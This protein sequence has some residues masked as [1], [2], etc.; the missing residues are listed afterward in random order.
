MADQYLMVVEGLQDLKDFDDLNPRI[1]TAA[2]RA[3]NKATDRGRAAAAR[4]M[5]KQVNFPHSYLR[6]SNSRLRVSQKATADRLEG[7]ITGR[8][9][10]TSLARFV[11]G[12]KSSARGI[13]VQVKPGRSKIIKNAFLMPLRAGNSDTGPNSNLGLAVRT[14]RGQRPV[15]AYKP[16]QVSDNLWLLYGPS[17]DQVFKTVREDVSPGVEEALE[18]E[19]LRLLRLEP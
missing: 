12:P 11:A 1:I 3:I 16:T 6:G 7:V 10:P 19:F 5:L 17:V 2:Y 9:R 13:R 4:E 8:Q 14:R 15:G 18:N